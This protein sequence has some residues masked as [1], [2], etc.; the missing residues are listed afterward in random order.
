MA[1]PRIPPKVLPISLCLLLSV[2]AHA[3][4][5]STD[6]APALT[7][8]G[9]ISGKV[10][11]VDDGDTL[12]VLE[13]SGHKRVVRL[14]DIDAPE[15]SHGKNRPGQ[16]YSA[17]ATAHLKTLAL[18][19]QAVARCFDIDVRVRDDGSRRDRYVCQVS[20]GQ[21]DLNLA[22]IDAGLAMAARQ[23]KRYV[24][25]P[26]TLVRE[27]AAKAARL[28]LWR[29]PTVIPPWTWRRSCWEQQVCG[30]AAE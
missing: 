13:G 22:M 11:H 29:Q 6:P 19:Q 30:G 21:L 14:S 24:R 28:G 8:P 26:A 2:A 23:N 12:V 15:T 7:M 16:P 27:D 18:G 3:R 17:Q 20:V 25:N 1:L 9:T 10:I 4:D 5:S